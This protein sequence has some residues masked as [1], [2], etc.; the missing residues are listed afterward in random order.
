MQAYLD[1][2]TSWHLDVEEQ[3]AS[4]RSGLMLLEAARRLTERLP[5]GE[6]TLLTRNEESAALVGASLALRPDLAARA[7]WQPLVIGREDGLHG[8]D[9]VLLIEAAPVGAGLRSALAERYPDVEV[10]AGCALM[11]ASRDVL[12]A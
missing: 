4:L 5:D 9:G 1:Q 2:T 8:L 6:L 10:I 12:A 11:P 3:R 7:T